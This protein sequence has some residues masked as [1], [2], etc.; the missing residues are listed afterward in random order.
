MATLGILKSGTPNTSATITG[1]KIK[2]TFT[3]EYISPGLT[4]VSWSFK[5]I[6]EENSGYP[7]SSSKAFARIKLTFSSSD[8]CSFSN[9][10]GNSY[11]SGSTVSSYP[12]FTGSGTTLG[13]G[14]SMTVT[15]NAEG[16]ATFKVS[17]DVSIGGYECDK[18]TTFTLTENMPYTKCGAP[19]S[20]TASGIITPSGTFTVKWSGATAGHANSISGYRVY[21][22]LSSNGRAPSIST[23][24]YKDVSA[25]ATSTSFTLSGAT[26][27][28]KIVCGVVA[29]G[30]VTGFDSDIKTGGLITINSLPAAPSVSVNKTIVP[31]AG[32][33]VTFTIVAG[34]DSNSSQ[35]RT[36][37][38]S[39]SK[40][41]T[42]SKI[43]SPWSTT[44][45]STTTYYFWTY[46]GLEY[47]SASSGTKISVNKKISFTVS[48]SGQELESVNNSSGK[49]YIVSPTITIS[50]ISGGQ[51]NKR[52]TYTLYYGTTES[53]TSSKVI[54]NSDS[55]TQKT[56]S[57]IRTLGI[58]HEGNGAYYQFSIQCNDGVENS[59]IV[60][61]NIMYVTKIPLL[62]G[63]YNKSD[64]SNIAN[65][66]NEGMATH[67]SKF[68][69]FKFQRDEG[70][71]L[72]KF[73]NHN[74]IAQTI[75]LITNTSDTR[76]SWTTSEEVASSI[77]YNLSYQLGYS[78]GYIH[79]ATTKNIIKIAKVSLSNFNFA[80]NNQIY[81]FFTDSGTYT[82][83]VGHSYAASP[84]TSGA[85][86]KYGISNILNK[87]YFFIKI[88]TNSKWSDSIG[89]APDSNST[90]N[91]TIGFN[92]TAASIAELVN[93]LFTS[94]QKNSDYSSTIRLYIK[95][96][97]GDE[98]YIDSAF[99]ISFIEKDNI[100]LVSKDI[101]P[102]GNK[103][104]IDQW[105]Y[106][107]E[108]M[109]SLIG[110]FTIKSYNT[111]PKGEIYIRRS[112]ETSWQSLTS[113]N[114]SGSGEAEP[115]SPISYSISNL[116]VQSIGEISNFNYNVN[117]RLVVR[118]DAGTKSFDIYSNI[119]VRGH[120]PAILIVSS[121]SYDG[122][123]LTINYNISN[124]GADITNLKLG[125]NKKISLYLQGSNEEKASYIDNDSNYFSTS[126]K[127][128]IF[129]Y[130]FNN[131]ESSLIKLGISTILSTYLKTDTS[132]SNPY[133]ETIKTTNLNEI[134]AGVIFNILPTV[135][136]RKN[137]LGINILE[138][139]IN[140]D[141][142][143]V[144]GEASGRD[145][146]YFQPAS[147]GFCKLV[148]FY[149]DGGSW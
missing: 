54:Y 55:A 63:L 36:L 64:F 14:G 59:S 112:T 79:S 24:T 102:Y 18:S 26:R 89:M 110:N 31:S 11:E 128:A 57:D 132:K 146:I 32:G 117:Y 44:V 148:N 97:F 108:G 48:I 75:N 134:E 81:K 114:F 62:T 131:S 77:N 120:I 139:S 70:Y 27:G 69:G 20:V 133:F 67:Y 100:S 71:N 47:S 33:Q 125:N 129:N 25:S 73:N 130:N 53:M 92:L 82:N 15:H 23:T 30:S 122:T 142:I 119:P 87:N 10:I 126:S 98:S 107:K 60:K 143:I 91:N 9:I 86:K 38:Y 6:Y 37:Y 56:V 93:N 68:L 3:Q 105:Q 19:T 88:Y 140:S 74:Q 2:T 46:D 42:K 104:Q 111:N 84:L 49:K 13:S 137:H 115:N 118:T 94:A 103:N 17:A 121:N 51:N 12:I 141:A 39:T 34:N 41:G 127:I 83:T 45:N 22:L 52:F 149:L 144:I 90:N 96:E 147:E 28:Y 66:S 145:T 138:P 40:T 80:F 116:V 7:A 95:N 5:A 85:I 76:G 135:A 16:L 109:G 136:Y 101:H 99:T 21:Y 43:T 1:F 50:D 58:N 113:F 61:S 78:N 123:N 4:K 29:K 124:F 35:T 106:L 8:G 72:L 65:F